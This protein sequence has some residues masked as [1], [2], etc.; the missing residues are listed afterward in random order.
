[1]R[2]LCWHIVNEFGGGNDIGAEVGIPYDDFAGGVDEFAG[3]AE[4]VAQDAPLPA[5]RGRPER[6]ASTSGRLFMAI[7][8]ASSA[9]F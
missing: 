9:G 7:M 5:R 6:A 1:M 4:I 8:V 3:G 2:L